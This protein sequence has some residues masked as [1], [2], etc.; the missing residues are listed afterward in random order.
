VR[1]P[2]TNF[3]TERKEGVNYREKFEKETGI[4]SI[5]AGNNWQGYV[6]W[7]ESRLEKSEADKVLCLI[8]NENLCRQINDFGHNHK[9]GE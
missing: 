3:F 1:L 7:L 5:F 9:T 6:E 8:E 4:K 2:A